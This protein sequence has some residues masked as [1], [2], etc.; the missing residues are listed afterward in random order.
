MA[1]WSASVLRRNLNIVSSQGPA[2]G[3]NINLK[4]CELHGAG[5]LSSFPSAIQT[6]NTYH[7]ELLGASIGDSEYF[8][9][10]ISRKHQAALDL[11]STL[12]EIGS[13]DPQVALALLCLCFVFCKLIH[14]ARVTPPQLILNAMQ[15]YDADIRCS[16]ANCTDVDVSD[17]AWKQAKM[18]LRRGGLGLRSLVDH[19]SA[20]Y[21]ASFCTS[22]SVLTIPY[23]DKVI[24][25]NNSCV[26]DCDTLSI[27][28]LK[29]NGPNQKQLSD[30]I[31]AL[32]FNSL[33]STSSTADRA[34]LLS[35]SSPHASAR[36]SLVPSTS[37]NLHFEPQEFNTALKWWLGIN[38]SMGL[39]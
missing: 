8:N 5:D 31:E 29:D 22:G 34:R 14:I 12:E 25:H 17:T 36:I 20:A 15:R 4:K 35:I 9:Q 23:L 6:S 3:F 32:Q 7:L 33:L 39:V 27:T 26:A 13:L 38:P 2:L 16:F 1:H 10:F 11:L 30:S 18:S 21:I 28:S 24:S 37:L 19:S